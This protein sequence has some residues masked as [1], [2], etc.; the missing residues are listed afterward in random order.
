LDLLEPYQVRRGGELVHAYIGRN[1]P[2]ER[3]VEDWDDRGILAYDAFEGGGRLRR[4]NFGFRISSVPLSPTSLVDLRG[5][6]WPTECKPGFT[7]RPTGKSV[8]DSIGP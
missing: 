3:R 5:P 2:A 6:D 4:T 7:N 8:P 1:Q